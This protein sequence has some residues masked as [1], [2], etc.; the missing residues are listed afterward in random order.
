MKS[1]MQSLYANNT[2]KLVLLPKG[3]KAIP[4]KWVYKVKCFDDKPKYKACLVAKGFA[5]KEGIDFQEIFSP[6]VKMTTLSVLF[7]LCAILDLELDQM[8]VVTAFLHGDLDEE[9]NMQ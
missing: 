7:A 5:Q 3:R 2:W 4:S 8:D 1:E 9:L 6:V